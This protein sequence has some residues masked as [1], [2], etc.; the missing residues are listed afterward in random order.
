M[1]GVGDTKDGTSA[2]VGAE[3]KDGFRFFQD[4]LI[5]DYLTAYANRGHYDTIGALGGNPT[6]LLWF[7][8]DRIAM[9]EQ[10]VER[11]KNEQ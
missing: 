1:D 10:E 9:L 4:R 5:C 11:L 3:A 6:N 7:L 2:T 8:F